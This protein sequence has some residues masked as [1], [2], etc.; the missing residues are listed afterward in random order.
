MKLLEYNGTDVTVAI[1]PR[2]SLPHVEISYH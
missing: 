2:S 1:V